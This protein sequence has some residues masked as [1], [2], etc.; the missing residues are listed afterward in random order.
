MSNYLED[1]F[2]KKVYNDT[3]EAEFYLFGLLYWI[4]FKKCNVK[5]TVSLYDVLIPKI[6]E[7]RNIYEN[8]N[9][10]RLGATRERIKSS[11]EIYSNFLEDYNDN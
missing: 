9:L 8:K 5:K 10:Q 3:T 2:I 11:I 4:L 6:N 7:H 1:D